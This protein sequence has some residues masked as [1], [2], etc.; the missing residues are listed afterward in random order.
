MSGDKKKRKK[1][2]DAFVSTLKLKR[3]EFR[4]EKKTGAGSATEAIE[5]YEY[6]LDKNRSWKELDDDTKDSDES[7]MSKAKCEVCKQGGDL[8]SCSQTVCQKYFHPECVRPHLS[9]E[10]PS[11]WSCAY[12]DVDYVTGLKPQA[13]KRRAAVSAV[14]AMEKTKLAIDSGKMAPEEYNACL[15]KRSMADLYGVEEN[16][17]SANRSQRQ[18]RSKVIF[19]PQGRDADD[20]QIEAKQVNE[21]KQVVQ[22]I[23]KDEIPIDILKK[24]SPK[25]I[26]ANSKHGQFHCKYCM[27]DEVTETCC[28]CACRVCFSKHE[29]D[30]TILCDICDAEYHIDCLSPPLQGIPHSDWFCPTCVNVIT[31]LQNDPKRGKTTLQQPKSLKA[32]PSVGKKAKLTKGN[33]NQVKATFA[34]KQPRLPSG[35]FAPKNFSPPDKPVKRGPGRPPKSALKQVAQ[36]KTGTGRPRGRP[37]K[38]MVHGLVSKEKESNT[39]TK[40]AD[41]NASTKRGR[42][43]P[44]SISKTARKENK[45]VEI[46]TSQKAKRVGEAEQEMCNKS[47]VSLVEEKEKLVQSLM[48]DIRT[49]DKLNSPDEKKATEEETMIKKSINGKQQESP[50]KQNNQDPMSEIAIQNAAA[51][52]MNAVVKKADNRTDSISRKDLTQNPSQKGPSALQSINQTPSEKNGGRMPRRKPGARECM[53]ISRRFGANIISQQYMNTLLVRFVAFCLFVFS[54]YQI[55]LTFFSRSFMLLQDYCTR[56]KVEHLIR[57]RERLDDHARFLEMQL[58]GLEM[59]IEEKNGVEPLQHVE[60]HNC[61]PKN[62]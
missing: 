62:R 58:A 28:F 10:P 30:R 25:C 38:N 59:M 32:T 20:S 56:G 1:V 55:K 17:N 39:G 53:Q 2:L 41:K 14:R 60:E 6:A 37:P 48:P 29:R 22:I 12:C 4:K 57:M 3:E 42:G 49:Y 5:F 18:R 27:D 15:K 45:K 19:D 35:R 21:T 34:S 46:E 9:G 44:P 36:K 24:L 11:D 40:T 47:S 52:A 61:I 16:G 26:N 43:R 13:R 51:A 54:L 33:R 7:P 50:F 8:I 31:K 23:D